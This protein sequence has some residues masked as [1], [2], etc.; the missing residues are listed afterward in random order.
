MSVA[1]FDCE[2]DIDIQCDG[3]KADIRVGAAIY[4]ATCAHNSQ[5]ALQTQECS[6]CRKEFTRAELFSKITGLFC[7]A[8][9]FLYEA[10][11]AGL[12]PKEKA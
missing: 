11:L 5:P 9:A 2:P 6:G 4:C 1:I 10:K 8:C 7:H 12:L 3:C